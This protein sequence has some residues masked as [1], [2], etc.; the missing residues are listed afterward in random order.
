MLLWAAFHFDGLLVSSA[1]SSFD[2]FPC[3]VAAARGRGEEGPCA[4]LTVAT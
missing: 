4:A 3:G 1:S 2:E